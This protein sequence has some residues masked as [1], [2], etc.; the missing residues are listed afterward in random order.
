LMR[1]TAFSA[2]SGCITSRD[3]KTISIKNSFRIASED[4]SA[5]ISIRWFE[6][7]EFDRNRYINPHS[8]SCSKIPC[9]P[10]SKVSSAIVVT[11]SFSLMAVPWL[12]TVL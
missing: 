9:L 1:F 2:L 11:P 7:I 8:T 10:A 6:S 3:N 12:Q 5:F 4:S